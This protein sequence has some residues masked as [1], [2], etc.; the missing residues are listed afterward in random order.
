[1]LVWVCDPSAP[2]SQ[3]LRLQAY[4]TCPSEAPVLLVLHSTKV[5][6][7]WIGL[8]LSNVTVLGQSLILTQSQ[9]SYLQNGILNNIYFLKSIFFTTET[10]VP[11]LLNPICKHGKCFRH[12]KITYGGKLALGCEDWSQGPS[13][14]SFYKTKK[15]RILL[16]H[17]QTILELYIDTIPRIFINLIRIKYVDSM[18]ASD[19]CSLAQGTTTEQ[20]LC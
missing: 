14:W 19:I 12:W 2:A 13:S 9:N 15:K 6:C 4:S 18:A 8:M 3:V 1:M 17:L 16:K 7:V 20:C 11:L 5:F 10:N